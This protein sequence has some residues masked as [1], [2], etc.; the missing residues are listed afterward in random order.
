MKGYS[1]GVNF[2]TSADCHGYAD[3]GAVKRAQSDFTPGAN[4]AANVKDGWA[5]GISK[6]ERDDVTKRFGAQPKSDPP[7]VAANPVKKSLGGAI[8]KAV[9]KVAKVS[10]NPI[11]A[12]KS[13]IGAVKQAAP[14]A[15]SAMNALPKPPMPKGGG[16]LGRIASKMAPAPSMPSL[17]RPAPAAGNGVPSFNRAPMIKMAQPGMMMAKGG[18]VV[19]PKGHK[20][21]KI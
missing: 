20:G 4:K 3:G 6:A 5:P 14:M 17:A 1:K 13:T 11:A 19:T 10:V 18:K 8:K 15:K 21:L 16:I 7:L 12:T 2:K 9:K